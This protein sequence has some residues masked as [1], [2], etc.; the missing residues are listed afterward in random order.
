[1]DVGNAYLEFSLRKNIESR[2]YFG[3]CSKFSKYKPNWIA[4]SASNPDY[5]I[6][7]DN[8][9]SFRNLTITVPQT[10]R[11]QNNNLWRKLYR[12]NISDIQPLLLCLFVCVAYFTSEIY[13]KWGYRGMSPEGQ[14][15][16]EIGKSQD[17]WDHGL[18]IK[19]FSANLLLNFPGCHR[20]EW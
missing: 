11:I 17:S 8:A 9:W 19:V 4:D 10:Q 13:K 20:W 5:F 1:M 2:W 7:K 16:K 15:L 14:E 6:G 3:V 18:L 12:G